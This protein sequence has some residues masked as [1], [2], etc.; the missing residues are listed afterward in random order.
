MWIVLATLAAL[1]RAEEPRRGYLGVRI[2]P[3]DAESRA[4]SG[5]TPYIAG[6]APAR[7]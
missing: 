1:A 7:P 3:V 5:H 4:A 6:F 2:G